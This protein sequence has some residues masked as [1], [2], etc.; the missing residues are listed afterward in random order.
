MKQAL[1]FVAASVAMLAACSRNEM[2]FQEKAVLNDGNLVE[3]VVFEA[4]LIRSLGE[5]HETRASLSQDGDNA[6]LFKWEASDTVGIYP[7][8]GSQVFFEITDGVGTNVASF[9]GGGWALREKSIYSCYFPFVCDMKLDRNAIPISFA[10]QVQTGISNYNGVRF[11]LASSG[12]SSSSGS[13]RFSFKML[14]T[15]IRVKAIGLPAGTYSKLSLTTDEPLFV[16]QGF[17]GLNDLSI[18]GKSFSDTLEISLKDFTLKEASTEENPVLIY[19]TSAPVDFRGHTVTVRAYS[20]D[21]RIYQCEKN[22]NKACEAGAWLGLKCVMEES[23]DGIVKYAKAS[24][25]TVGGTYLI[26]DSDDKRLFKGATDGLFANVSPENSIITDTDGSLADYEFTVE[27]SGSNYYL[28]FNDGKYLVCNYNNNSSTG[29]AYANTPS[30]VKYPYALTTGTNGTF[31]FNTT[32]ENN[33]AKTDQFLYFK[34]S[35]GIFKIGGS[36]DT[37]GVHLYMKDGKQDRGLCFD[38]MSVTCTLGSIPEKPVL[39]GTYTAVTYSSSDEKI[40][41]VDSEG[42]VTTLAAGIVTITATAAEDDQYSAGS[43]AYTLKIKS[44]STSGKYVRVTSIDKINLDGEYVIVYEEGS[45][46]K[47]FKPILNSN[48]NAFSTASNNAIDII[49]DNNEIEADEVDDC[50]I[51]LANQDGTTKKFSLVVPEADGTSDYYW[52]VYR[53]GIFT[54][55][56][57]SDN[58]DDTGYRSSFELSPAGALTLKGTNNYIL[59]YSSGYFTA[60]TGTAPNNLYLFVREGGSVKQKQTLG[61]AESTVNWTLGEGYEAGQSYNFPQQVTGAQTTVTYTCEP[62]SVAKIEGGKIKIVGAGSATVTA[63]AEKNDQYY[64]ASASYTLRI[65]KPAPEGW[66]DMGT[67]N[68]ENRALYYYLNDALNSYSDNDDATN[69]V[70]ATY[71]TGSDYASIDR[72]DCPNPVTITWTN[73]ASASTVISIYEND[74]LAN[75]VWIQNATDR[76]TSADVFNLIPGRTYYYTV[77][78]DGSIW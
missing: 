56:V 55:K 10:D 35:D 21:G 71:A 40:A 64:A 70:M 77:S 41:T 74:A 5:D 18:T 19:L 60:S 16:Q 26:V 27:N 62:E 14:N 53:S 68:L 45:V 3:R 20:E 34:T 8:K 48:K 51:A 2:D 30:E 36:G 22:P 6:V 78:E 33:T 54:A 17:F 72:K 1:L 50:R 58:S 63:T 24:S 46:Q 67:F 49:I 61:F 44:G 11:S 57:Y 43:A 76:A 28:K 4:P 32:Q 7:D 23:D 12:T 73:S 69:T 66:V 52:Y 65:I 31:F 42:N 39:S 37:I 29:L 9:D 15:I 38:P 25:I 59:R 13:L 47:A 75:P